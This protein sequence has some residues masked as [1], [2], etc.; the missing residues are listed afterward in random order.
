MAARKRE[1][2]MA[3]IPTPT[4]TNPEINMQSLHAVLERAS[5]ELNQPEP[6]V[7]KK[8]ENVVPL[9]SQVSISALE[10]I[11]GGAERFRSAIDKAINDATTHVTNDL[12]KL[13]NEIEAVREHSIERAAIAK[14]AIMEH[15]DWSTEAALF[16]ETIRIRMAMFQQPEPVPAQEPSPPPSLGLAV[17]QSR[18][19]QTGPRK[20]ES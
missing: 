11:K 3:K 1:L 6:P 17:E 18:P 9:A 12:T 8:S 10:D 4:P 2:T 7:K 14:N 19:Q 5:Q 20:V 16:A 15:F 13:M